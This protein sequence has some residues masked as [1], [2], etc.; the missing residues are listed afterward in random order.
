MP[1]IRRLA[2]IL[3]ADVAGY[4]RLIGADEE[5]TVRRLK[6]VRA[7]LI[8]PAIGKHNGRIVH[9]AGDGLLVEFASV[10]DAMRCAIEWQAATGERTA[11]QSGDARIDWRIGVNLGDI[12]ID[13]DDIHGDGV[14]IAA[15]LEA[16]AEPGGICVSRTV[17][18]HT[19]GKLDFP[20]ADLGDQA[21][22]N[23]AQPIRV[24][25]VLA[26]GTPMLDPPVL[27][28]PD[29]P[30]I[31]VL[32]F[33]NMS[34]DPEQEY[35]AD[36]MVEEIITAL[37]RIRWL[38][39]IARNSTS[40]YKGQAVDVKQ[41]G[42]ELG[43]RYV[44]E[45]S[46]RKG[47]GRVRIN[48]QLIEAEAGAHLWA[49]RFDGS[50][51]DVFDLQD[52]VAINVAGVI[53]PAL[54]AAE[55]RRSMGRSTN[56]L[57]AYDLYLRALA[58]Y[59][60]ITQERAFKTLELLRQALAIDRHYGPALSWAAICLMRLYREGWAEDPEAT[61]RE[62]VDLARQALPV[63]QDDPAILANAAFVLANFGE[64]IGAMIGLVDRA[65]ALTPSFSRGWFVSGVL[66]MWAG[67]HDLAIE[68]AKSALRLSPR[69]R[70]GTPLSLIGEAHFY[71]REFD[72]AAAQLLLSIQHNPGFPH[73]FRVLAACYAQMGRLDEARAIVA[74]LRAITPE[75]VPTA[76]HLR[77]AEDR[78]LFLSGL[79]LASSDAG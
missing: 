21:L 59:Y 40:T 69:E 17:L 35:F 62:A 60:P 25:R 29:K 23:I 13:D 67:Q 41:V 49:D 5:G 79:R 39:V 4:S 3:A 1:A 44:L 14:N 73:S 32:P 47:G 34:G 70:G 77:R 53:E 10:V 8:D 9:T 61:R 6:S 64:D 18:S 27:P 26:E 20:V 16:M 55:G 12:V 57:T 71:Q 45:G 54:Q 15:R 2:A 51:E 33:Q 37:S 31:A 65:L 38:F 48:A 72:E 36:G 74:R 50:L 75:I 52:Q 76:T 28:L 46:V 19:R 22:K 43:V 24:F 68:H 56:D 66:R 42:R 63:A 7:E 11:A 58:T 30:S 78:E